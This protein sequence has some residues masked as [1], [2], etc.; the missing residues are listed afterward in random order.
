MVAI[1]SPSLPFCS[2]SARKH[3][4]TPAFWDMK[5]R[6]P[7]SLLS[8]SEP[9]LWHGPPF[10]PLS[11]FGATGWSYTQEL[12]AE[13]GPRDACRHKTSLVCVWACVIVRATTIMSMS[14]SLRVC[15]SMN[16]VCSLP[17]TTNFTSE[18]CPHTPTRA[19]YPKLKFASR[20]RQMSV[21]V[22]VYLHAGRLLPHMQTL[23]SF[24]NS[25]NPWCYGATTKCGQW[26][27]DGVVC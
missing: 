14:M 12:A 15:V 17:P 6:R 22:C 4:I 2:F 3:C 11:L 27:S 8:I 26:V 13:I 10:N 20:M 18:V 9:K 23:V 24:G 1:C 19:C 16:C 21:C 7:T 5:W 25:S